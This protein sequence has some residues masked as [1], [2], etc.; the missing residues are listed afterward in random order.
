MNFKHKFKTICAMILLVF[1]SFAFAGCDNWNSWFK[2]DLDAATITINAN[3]KTISWN[4]V[5][6]AEEYE[7][8]ANETK[9]ATVVSKSGINTYD[10][11]GVL[12]DN[13]AVYKFYI[14]VTAD[15][16]NSSPKSNVVTFLNSTEEAG[17]VSTVTISN[18]AL[19]KV[20]NLEVGDSILS[21]DTVENADKYYV[22]IR[23][24][25]LGENVFETK[26]NAFNFSAYVDNDDV[27]MFRVGVKDANGVIAMSLPYYHNTCTIQPTYHNKMFIIDGVLGDHYISDQTELN[28][29]VYYAF[30]NRVTEVPVYFSAN[31]MNELVNTHGTTRKEYL[32]FGKY[33][34]VDFYHLVKAVS[35]ACNSFTETCAY[36][37]GLKD[38][39]SSDYYKK[40]FKITF[41][42]VMG[43]EPENTTSKVREQNH[44]DTPYYEK[45]DYEKRAETYNDFVS[46]KRLSVE[47]VSTT[48]QLFHAVESGSTP[49]FKRVNDQKSSA[50]E[51]Y[52]TA[53][54]ILREIISDEMTDYEK[55]LSIFDY[56]CFNTIYDDMVCDIPVS[57][58]PSF[59]SYTSFFLEGVFYD[60][61]SV[62]DGFSKAFSLLCNMEGIKA[63]RI[64]GTV[65]GNG[66]AWN[67]VNLNG[68]WYVI[69]ITWSVVKSGDGEDEGHDV[70]LFRNKEFL[71]YRYFLVSD[72][73]IKST[74]TPSNVYFD[75]SIPAFNDYYYYETHKYDGVNN[76]II[77]SDEEFAA[78]V[79]YMLQNKQYS[80]EVAFDDNY[81]KSPQISVIQHDEQFTAACKRV[82]A[83]CGIS[84]G[85]IFTPL[86]VDEYGNIV[87]SHQK[88]ASH[89]MATIYSITLINLPDSVKQ[90]A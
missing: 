44:E 30:I 85:N 37:T 84:S 80:M 41:D 16:Y 21:W 23:T 59:A 12:K 20:S 10:F 87:Y 7:V 78:L 56:I 54:G 61:L 34:T 9:V 62:C 33:E 18:N 3:N 82:K 45:V 4:N 5:T 29:L 52:D 1:S 39:T 50:E 70:D 27:V 2:P 83:A 69:D 19:N 36:D 68:C 42:Y 32:G 72:S 38:V 14:I 81:I 35:D 17:V 63:Y 43:V 8:F 25:T 76:M 89:T 48:E 51:L 49:L 47:F 77:S 65:K 55:V 57:A 22:Y 24:N 58:V 13:V 53:K 11:S 40:D 31:F 67:K 74:H 64:S 73:Y 90:A 79:N 86:K 28:H 88:V 26:V 15:E 75:N 71:S 46:D 66:H 6:N 60:G